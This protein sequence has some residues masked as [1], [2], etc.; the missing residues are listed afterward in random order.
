[1]HISLS[2]QDILLYFYELLGY[3]LVMY[4]LNLEETP[5]VF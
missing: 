1:M 2:V 3:K 5:S 4:S